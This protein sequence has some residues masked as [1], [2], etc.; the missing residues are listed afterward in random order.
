MS[1]LSFSLSVDLAEAKNLHFIA[2][3][4]VGGSNTSS[5]NVYAYNPTTQKFGPVCDDNW[6]IADVS[7]LF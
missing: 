5:G 4:L 6:D 3:S 7:I 1:T 2:V